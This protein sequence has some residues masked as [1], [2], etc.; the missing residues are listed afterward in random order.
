MSA[1]KTDLAAEAVDDVGSR[2]TD[3]HIWDGHSR[4]AVAIHRATIT[5]ASWAPASDTVMA[6]LAVALTA[7]R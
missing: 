1:T 2:T 5:S 3:A 7:P 6:L 4:E